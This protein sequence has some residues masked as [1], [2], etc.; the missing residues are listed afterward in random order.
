MCLSK[1]QVMKCIWRWTYS[2][3]RSLPERW[4]ELSGYVMLMPLSLY[5]QGK[6]AGTYRQET[7]WNVGPVWAKKKY[8][9]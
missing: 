6:T 5:S 9:V 4:F 1:H 8:Q 7:G 2:S 3:V